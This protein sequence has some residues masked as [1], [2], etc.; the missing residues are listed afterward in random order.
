MTDIQMYLVG[1]AVRDHY[2]GV[3]TK[4]MDYTV[5]VNPELGLTVDEA[6]AFMRD[7]LDETGF[8][9]FL[10]TPQYQTIRAQ[11]PVDD[12]LPYDSRK[13]LTADFVLARKEGPYSDGRRP[14]WVTVG[15]L[16][17]DLARR[18][19]TVNS[20]A[21]DSDM[22]LID[23]HGGLEDLKEKRLRAVGDPVARL[24]EDALRAFRAIR[25]AIT[26]GFW[27]DP[28]LHY[29]MKTLKVLDA[30]E[31]N[32]SADRIKDELHRCF[33]HDSV[34]TLIFLAHKFPEYL[35]IMKRKGIWLEPSLRKAK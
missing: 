6:Y 22:N 24:E 10:E 26:K 25:F 4:D 13:G 19:F 7:Y 12:S 33:V 29:A 1:G 30:L 5:T 20:L 28:D 3:K 8:K 18:D 21:F 16:E 17:D 31:D 9:I 2:L 35:S 14:D 34:G 11:F 23:P 15:T 27:I 32:I